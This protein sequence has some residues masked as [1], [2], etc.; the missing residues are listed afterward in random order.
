MEPSPTSILE[1]WNAVADRYLELFR[2]EMRAKEFD[3]AILTEFAQQL[4]KNA[5]L[6][7]AGCGPCGHVTRLLA[8][9][10]TRPVG[11]DIASRCIALA[12]NEQPQLRF[13]VM[14]MAAMAFAGASFDGLLCYYALHYE[15][16]NKLAAL[17]AEFARVLRP[18]GSLLIVVKQGAS[19]GWI[20]D[21]LGSGQKVYWSD[22]T[23]S[24]LRAPLEDAGFTVTRTEVRDPLPDE[25]AVRRIYLWARRSPRNKES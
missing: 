24:E 10:G 21:P 18:N 15:P 9:A 17:F 16:K 19:E 8:D 3:R 23:S 2:D 1:Y 4:P 20:D 25:I 6:C 13:E 7:D 22:F 12:R 5:S 14:D 11:I